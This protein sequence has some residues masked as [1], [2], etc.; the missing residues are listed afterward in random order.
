MIV[1]DDFIKKVLIAMFIFLSIFTIAMVVVFILTGSTPDTLI[2]AVFGACMGEYSIC[3]LI[4]KSKEKEKTER[5][6]QG[7][8]EDF[9]GYIEDAEDQE[10]DEDYNEIVAG[11]PC[12]RIE[13]FI[14]A[15]HYGDKEE[16]P[17]E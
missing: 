11:A 5:I 4:K 16:E 10:E 15:A 17:I 8:I 3:G 6:K 2:A 1:K 12:G 14:S 13:E 7:F 9:D